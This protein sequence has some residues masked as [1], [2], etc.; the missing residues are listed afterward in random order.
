[1]GKGES[2]CKAPS[3][4]TLQIREIRHEAEAPSCPRWRESR[5][6][7]SSS[8]SWSQVFSYSDNLQNLQSLNGIKVYSHIFKFQIDIPNLPVTQLQWIRDS[9]SLPHLSLLSSSPDFQGHHA[10][11]L[12]SWKRKSK[13]DW[14]PMEIFYI[15]PGNRI[16]H[17]HSHSIAENSVM[18]SH[19]T[20]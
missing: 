5:R 16:C 2:P 19:L 14:S 1:M 7:G 3:P 13:T 6:A 12:Q 9:D 10:C 17:F 11:L 18:W 4:N 15:R 20:A 8:H